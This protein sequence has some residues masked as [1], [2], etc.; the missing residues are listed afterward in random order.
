M[1]TT[2]LNPQ[3]SLDGRRF[4][5]IVLEA[6]H[7]AGDADSLIF[8]GGRFRSTACDRYG[9]GDGA[10]VACR[11]GDRIA[12]EAE[13]ESIRYGRLRWGGTVTGT[14]LDGTLTM[15]RDGAPAGE[16]WV[17]AGEVQPA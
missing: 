12:F 11:D 5:G 4:D 15:L 9:Y 3:T 1:N 16:K 7:T 14:R 13:T 2:P 17:L 10:Y 8:E 6:G